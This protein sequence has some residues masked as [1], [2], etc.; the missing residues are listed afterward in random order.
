MF[1][2]EARAVLGRAAH[3][4]LALAEYGGLQRGT[5]KLVASQTKAPR[6]ACWM[7]PPV[8]GSWR[9]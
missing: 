3:A 6:S 9:S 2:D 8:W 4:E 1:L 5:L 7:V